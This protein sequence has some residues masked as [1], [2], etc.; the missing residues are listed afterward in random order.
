MFQGGSPQPIRIPYY[1][2]AGNMMKFPLFQLHSYSYCKKL[3]S[4]IWFS[5]L[6]HCKTNATNL[7]A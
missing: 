4:K 6:Q 5:E 7:S 2:Q 3:D 1:P